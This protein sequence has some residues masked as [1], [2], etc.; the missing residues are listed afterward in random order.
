[1]LYFVVHCKTYAP[2]DIAVSVVVV[3]VLSTRSRVKVNQLAPFQ[4]NHVKNSFSITYRNSFWKKSGYACLGCTSVIIAAIHS[5]GD[6]R[7]QIETF[8]PVIVF[9]YLVYL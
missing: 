3:V 7:V 4:P 6:E 1:V 2:P 5:I 8:G 9:T